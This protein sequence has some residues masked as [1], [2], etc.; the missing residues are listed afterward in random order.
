MLQFVDNGAHDNCVIKV[1]QYR[2]ENLSI[3][4]YFMKK[5]AEDFTLKHHLLFEI[6]AY[7]IYEKL[8]YKHSDTIEY[9]KN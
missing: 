7:E 9:V 1:H 6:C 4:L 3:S 5:Y 8:V 2:F